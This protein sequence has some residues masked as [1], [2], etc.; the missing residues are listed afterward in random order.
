MKKAIFVTVFYVVGLYASYWA[1]SAGCTFTR[2]TMDWFTAAPPL[3]QADK[4]PAPPT[5]DTDDIA[6]FVTYDMPPKDR[7]AALLGA[8]RA[9]SWMS[10]HPQIEYF[11]PSEGESP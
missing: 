9:V 8:Q 2:A 10:R 11:P 5:D 3:T 4:A 7:P 6:S 1:Y